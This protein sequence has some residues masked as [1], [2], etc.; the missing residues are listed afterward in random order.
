MPDGIMQPGRQMADFYPLHLFAEMGQ[1]LVKEHTLAPQYG[2]VFFFIDPCSDDTPVKKFDEMV[3]FIVNA[4]MQINDAH[5]VNG[6][7]FFEL[8]IVWFF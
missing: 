2:S 8:V 4:L 1:H 5:T 7:L 3:K 6:E